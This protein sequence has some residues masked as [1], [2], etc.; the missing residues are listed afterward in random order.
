MSMGLQTSFGCYIP[1]DL[2]DLVVLEFVK[3]SVRAD[4]HVIKIVHSILLMSDFWIASDHSTDPAQV[5]QLSLTVTKRSTD[6]ESARKDAIRANE[7]VLFI[8]TILS[9]WHCLLF[10]LVCLGCR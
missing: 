10:Y 9:W 5:S 4:K 8:I 1:D 7:G 3:D 6:R 2:I